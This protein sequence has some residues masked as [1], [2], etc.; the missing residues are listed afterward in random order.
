MPDSSSGVGTELGKKGLQFTV[1]IVVLVLLKAVVG[2]LPMLK[3]ASAIGSTLLSRQ[4]LANAVV[5]TLILAVVGRFGL[6]ISQSLLQAYRRARDLGEAVAMATLLLVLVL[7]YYFYQLPLACLAVSPQDL[8]NV[9]AWTTPPDLSQLERQVGDA[10]RQLVNGMSGSLTDM[11]KSSPGTVLQA[12]QNLAVA[13]LR[14]PPDV[15]GWIFLAL[16]AIPVIG[17]VVLGARNLNAIS[18]A[19][20]HKNSSGLH[21]H[22]GLAGGS[23][24]RASKDLSSEDMDKLIR[25][26]TLLDQG[27]ITQ[28]DFD[29]QKKKLLP[30]PVVPDEPTELQMLKQ[31]LD[32]GALT[33]GEYDV[34][35]Q[36]FLARL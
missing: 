10:Y 28:A 26:K 16:S 6:A 25:L 14:Q 19:L 8:F 36:R 32:A 4:V 15:Y 3:D 12:Y 21:G 29:T 18:E 5:D 17:I 20:F 9:G 35:K 13:R 22:S 1:S 34:Q 11:L 23:P 7:A 27:A 33:Q 2:A 30:E 31:L 24:S